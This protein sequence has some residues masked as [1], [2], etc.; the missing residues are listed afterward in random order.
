MRTYPPPKGSVTPFGY[1][2]LKTKDRRQKFEHV[3]VWE[4]HH[5]PVPPGKETGSI[6]RRVVPWPY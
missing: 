6:W 1:R 5:G 4:Q 2:R 3:L